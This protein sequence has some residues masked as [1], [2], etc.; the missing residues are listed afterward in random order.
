MVNIL[1][2]K[3]LLSL[4]KEKDYYAWLMKVNQ[5]LIAPSFILLLELANG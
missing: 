5:T 2:M 4:M 1:K 3:V